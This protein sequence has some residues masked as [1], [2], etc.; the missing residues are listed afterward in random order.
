MKGNANANPVI[1]R[2][3]C[4][5]VGRSEPAGVRRAAEAFAADVRDV[6]GFAP[7]RV[8]SRP[9]D[10]GLAIIV[11]SEG[12]LAERHG[13]AGEIQAQETFA[14]R[15]VVQEDK[16]AI[17][18]SGRGERGA[19][20]GLYHLSETHLG[21]DPFK[22]WTGY[23][24]PARDPIVLEDVDYTAPPPSF[25]FRGWHLEG[26]ELF[27]PWSGMCLDFRGY[28]EM[29]C[30]TLLRCRGNM[31]KPNTNR[32]DSPEVALAQEMGLLI[33]QEHC[34][35]FGLGML[36]I[37]RGLRRLGAGEYPSPF[38][39]APA[40]T[41]STIPS[42]SYSFDE[43]PEVFVEAWRTAMGWYPR[44]ENVIWTLGY[45]GRGDRPFWEADPKYDSDA[46]RGELITRVIR[47]QK[48]LVEER[49]GRL[50][51]SFI[52][53]TWMEGNRLYKHGHTRLPED[54]T[55]VWADNGYGTFRSMTA[56]GCPPEAVEQILP[57]EPAGGRHG[58]YY[59][60]S[61]WNYNTPVLTQFVPL[62]RI[63]H[64]F[65][66]AVRKQCTAYLLVN[67]GRL[68]DCVL[69]AAAIADLWRCP[70]RWTDSSHHEYDRGGQGFLRRWCRRY[71]GDQAEEVG[72]CY[73]ALYAGPITWGEWNGWHDC[74]VGDVGYVRR[75]WWF[76]AQALNNGVRHWR[77]SEP[78]LYFPDEAKSLSERMAFMRT[79]TCAAEP[80]WHEA[81]EQALSIAAQLEGEAR[82]FFDTDVLSQIEIHKFFNLYLRHMID[83]ITL[84]ERGLGTAA[85]AVAPAQA[86]G[87]CVDQVQSAMMRREYG[88]WVGWNTEKLYTRACLPLARQCADTLIDVIEALTTRRAGPF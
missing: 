14:I 6:A 66:R 74:I 27:E 47:V 58:T 59:H 16:P 82:H 84:Y 13:L 54:V 40:D 18:V 69:G 35:P 44:P 65:T 17:L 78:D 4:I 33:T 73:D 67:V 9:E 56:E 49:C 70:D 8:D 2:S 52:H 23:R 5:V 72:E 79:R 76:T 32:P 87:K 29:V 83:A 11:E 26:I 22:H 19:I 1:D 48:E 39:L 77:E 3:T 57:D 24:P 43:S 7:R 31:I 53:N 81:H 25:R 50:D 85:D 61:M 36:D 28:W 15:A 34:N 88:K 37:G 55:V 62:E 80:A 64:E 20:Y 10:A 42:F 30:E 12:Q 68:R 21:T 51:P 60:V 41:E 71:F 63:Q 45:R 75:A 46:A 38:G 86:A